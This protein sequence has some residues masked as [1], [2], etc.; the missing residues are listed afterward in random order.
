MSYPN[1]YAN[2]KEHIYLYNQLTLKLYKDTYNDKDYVSDKTQI[3]SYH[4]IHLKYI[5]Y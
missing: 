5:I 3:S 4:L 2:N 1:T